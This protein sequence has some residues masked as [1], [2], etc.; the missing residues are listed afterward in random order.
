MA[1]RCRASAKPFSKVLYVLNAIEWDPSVFR[2]SAGE[3]EAK[4]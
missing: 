4:E 2:L 1:V 3:Q